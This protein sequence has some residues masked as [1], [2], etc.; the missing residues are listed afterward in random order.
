[1][2]YL[3]QRAI[4]VAGNPTVNGMQVMWQMIHVHDAQIL[5]AACSSCCRQKIRC[6]LWRYFERYTPEEDSSSR[7]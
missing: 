6:E 1:M 5:F 3:L 7:M 4:S 2:Q